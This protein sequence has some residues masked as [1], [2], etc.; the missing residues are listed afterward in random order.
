MSRARSLEELD[1]QSR[2][3]NVSRSQRSAYLQM[4]GVY[5]LADGTAG[6]EE[7]ARSLQVD[8]GCFG[9]GINPPPPYA[10][11]CYAYSINF[12]ATE[13]NQCCFKRLQD[14]NHLI[15]VKDTYSFTPFLFQRGDMQ[16]GI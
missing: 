1:R 12:P 15:T 5:A 4:R 2:R 11:C 9:F 14:M 10:L 8:T 3:R 6:K 13:Q 7:A 16:E